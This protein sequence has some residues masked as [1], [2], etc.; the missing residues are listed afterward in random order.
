MTDRV[1][2]PLPTEERQPLLV[3]FSG[4]DGAGKST[5]IDGLHIRLNDAGL[6]V[7]R[8]E[9]WNDIAVLRQFREFSRSALF[10]GDTGVGA[11][12]KPVDRR[13]KNVQTWYMHAFRF[14]LYFLDAVW[15]N[16]VAIQ[17]GRSNSDVV[18]YDRYLYDEL[19]NLP[20]RSR[21][22]RAYIRLLLK[23]VSRPD[24]AYLLDAD[25]EQARERKPEYPIEFVRANRAN[26]L[27][28]SK[29]CGMT[30]I[31]PG[32][33]ATVEDDVMQQ[34]LKRL[35]PRQCEAIFAVGG[36]YS[37]SPDHPAPSATFG[38]WQ[39]VSGL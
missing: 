27:A 3:S 15:L 31:N 16:V 13:D 37:A 34:L 38:E 28:L 1:P 36:Q 22:A 23:L 17:T 4:I 6:R 7:R 10:K 19:A 14:F 30:V 2:I 25:P 21:I 39:K 12:G 11:P 32:P 9:F 20:L 18:I 29:L 5:Q 35:S 24:I 33:T 8:L 26:Y